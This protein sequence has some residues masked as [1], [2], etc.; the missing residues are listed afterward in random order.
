MIYFG[1]IK[2]KSST[3]QN[4]R[5]DEMKGQWLRMPEI[6]E[7]FQIFGESLTEGMDVRMISTT[8]V[9]AVA[10]IL[11]DGVVTGA[12]FLTENSHY[13]LEISH[14]EGVQ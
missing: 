4:L 9:K 5:T 11:Y 14:I 6:G 13:E 2:K 1:T 7:S 3:H 10:R 12:I 8:P